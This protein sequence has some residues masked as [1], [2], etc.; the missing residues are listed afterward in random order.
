MAAEPAKDTCHFPSTA[1]GE[2]EVRRPSCPRFGVSDPRLI[3]VSSSKHSSVF[4]ATAADLHVG[5]DDSQAVVTPWKI[6]SSDVD[7]N[8][9]DDNGENR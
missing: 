7:E 4:F 8:G 9:Y 6:P 2:L 1:Q 5:G 3:P